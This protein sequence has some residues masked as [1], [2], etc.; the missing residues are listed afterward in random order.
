MKKLIFVLIP[1]LL[2][3]SFAFA[4]GK[5]ALRRVIDEY[6]FATTV[7]WDQHDEAALAAINASF[8]K[9]LRTLIAE[10]NYTI[11]DLR[12]A[13]KGVDHI[14]PAV[15][16]I[17]KGKDGKVVL[18]NL[19][20]LIETRSESMYARGSSWSPGAVFGIGLGILLVAEIAVLIMNEK[21]DVCPNPGVFAEDVRYECQWPN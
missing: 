17:L 2:I 13:L 12:E 6:Q 16:E 21:D 10:G 8:D 20:D 14:D 5:P 7:E 19:R 15:L 3:Q 9:E 4:A 18:E 11:A 1:C